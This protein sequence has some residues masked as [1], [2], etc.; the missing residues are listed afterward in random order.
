VGRE[1]ERVKGEVW[2]WGSICTSGNGFAEH[3][4]EAVNECKWIFWCV[5]F[6]YNCGARVVKI[7]TL[8]CNVQ[9]AKTKQVQAAGTAAPVVVAKHKGGKLVPA[10]GLVAK[11]HQQQQQ[12]E[13]KTPAL[14]KAGM[15]RM[16]NLAG[17]PLNSKGVFHILPLCAERVLLSVL[18]PAARL[19]HL[20]KTTRLSTKHVLHVL[21]QRNINVVGRF[22]QKKNAAKVAPAEAS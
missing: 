8:I 12:H 17:H 14:R 6:F 2:F 1:G 20:G 18:K 4:F 15:T 16:L 13:K 11:R 9:M 22:P 3:F 7:G 19:A 21:R 5:W 10:I